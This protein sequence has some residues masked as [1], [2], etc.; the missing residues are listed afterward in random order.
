MNYPQEQVQRVI[1]DLEN[2][3]KSDISGTP[4]QA[5]IKITS[6][7]ESTKTINITPEQLKQIQEILK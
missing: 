4:N 3:T 5:R 6:F 2:K 1:D 7:Y